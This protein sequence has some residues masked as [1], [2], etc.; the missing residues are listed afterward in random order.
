MSLR[1]TRL[2]AGPNNVGYEARKWFPF[3]YF[4]GVSGNAPGAGTPEVL[5]ALGESGKTIGIAG[6]D[7]RAT[8]DELALYIPNLWDVDLTKKIYFDMHVYFEAATGDETLSWAGTAIDFN[9][10]AAAASL[11][12]DDEDTIT[13]SGSSSI[14]YSATNLNNIR[15][16]SGLYLAAS[17][18][19][20]NDHGV[21]PIFIATLAGTN[22]SRDMVFVG[23]MMRYTPR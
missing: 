15:V 10:D 20:S 18:I 2:V 11:I 21:I 19:T 9:P 12:S 3:Q 4:A 1:G 16:M 23:M 14:A 13:L 17:T 22:A 7:I 6:L 5:A 8:N